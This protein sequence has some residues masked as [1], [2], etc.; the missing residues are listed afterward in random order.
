MIG[1][2]NKLKVNYNTN[3]SFILF[4]IVITYSYSFFFL[5]FSVDSAWYLEDYL[6]YTFL[7]LLLIFGLILILTKIRQ[8]TV[9]LLNPIV[10]FFNLYLFST[11]ISSL[12]SGLGFEWVLIT[13]II[14]NLLILNSNE[15]PS[16][17]IFSSYIIYI[18]T[19]ILILATI[20][21]IGNYFITRPTYGIVAY[22]LEH[23]GVLIPRTSGISRMIAFIFVFT[24]VY[25]LVFEKNQSKIKKLFLVLFLIFLMFIIIFVFQ[26][27]GTILSLII[28]LLSIIYLLYFRK[29]NLIKITTILILIIFIICI[30]TF[31]L[32]TFQIGRFTDLNA[33]LNSSGRISMWF[34]IIQKQKIIFIGNGM[35]ADRHI[36]GVN[37]SNLYLYVYLSAGFMG[38]SFFLLHILYIFKNVLYIFKY[39]KILNLEEKFIYLLLVSIFVFLAVRSIFENSFAIYGYDLILWCLMIKINLYFKIEN[40]KIR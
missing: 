10:L 27:R 31:L 18:F 12:F 34:D 39:I 15:N 25:Y 1:F 33:L 21:L 24:L 2:L 35:Q 32:I 8:S 9:F 38:L 28:S 22:V 4:Q 23:K 7:L 29:K 11:F 17:L 19:I 26:S 20:I 14:F 5:Y 37:V 6:K 3:N 13:T 40:E 16:K 30:I 36:F